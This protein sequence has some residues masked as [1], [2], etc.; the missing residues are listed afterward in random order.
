LN[1][2]DIISGNNNQIISRFYLHPYIQIIQEDKCFLISKNNL[3]LAKIEIQNAN[4]I[5]LINTTYH[6]E[7]GNS[8]PNKCIELNSLSPCQFDI[9]IKIL[10]NF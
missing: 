9:T 7:F 4:S 8:L 1:I 5:K 3:N 10:Y 6:D 2:S